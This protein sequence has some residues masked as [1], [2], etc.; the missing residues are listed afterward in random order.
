MPAFPQAA[1]ELRLT[2]LQN[3]LL[4]VEPTGPGLLWRVRF[5]GRA[6]AWPRDE[7]AH[8]VAELLPEVTLLDYAMSLELWDMTF[9]VRRD[10]F[11]QN[12]FRQ[13]LVTYLAALYLLQPTPGGSA[14]AL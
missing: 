12:N 10:T 11:G 2:G 7:Y 4:T 8:R 6:P 3:L 14:L 1:D 5:R 13:M 9:R